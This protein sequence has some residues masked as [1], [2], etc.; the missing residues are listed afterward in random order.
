MAR[1]RRDRGEEARENADRWLLTYADMITLLMVLFVVMY[2][3]SNTDLRKFTV[4]AQSFSAAFNTDVLQGQQALTVTDAQ[5]T[6]QGLTMFDAG[7]GAIATD[8][9]SVTAFVADYAIA[10]GLANEVSVDRVAEGIAIRINEALLFSSGRA[11]L[12]APALEIAAK[13]A[14]IIA[15][16][17]NNIRVEGHTD[18]QPPTGPFYADNWELSTARAMAVLDALRDHGVAPQRLS[19]AGYAGYQPLVPNTSDANRARNRRV[20]I[21]VLYPPAQSATPT[22]DPFAIPSPIGGQP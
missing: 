18:D 15:P 6:S 8:Y 20:D 4:L 13:I 17:P 10:N 22:T 2:A 9:R 11:R 16:L 1:R 7:E 5:Q 19:A 3:V 14:S 12:D 21:L